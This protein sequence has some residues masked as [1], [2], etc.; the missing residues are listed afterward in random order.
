MSS[1]QG[2]LDYLGPCCGYSRLSVDRLGNKI[3]YEVQQ[4]PS[5]SWAERA[6]T[7]IGHWYKD[8]NESA[9]DKDVFRKDFEEMLAD[10]RAGLWK[11]IIVWRIDRLT[12]RSGQFEDI[13]EMLE[14]V[15]GF[16]YSV[17][18]GLD[19]RNED[20]LMMMKIKVVLGDNEV[21]GTKRRLR[22]NKGAKT[23]A[24]MYTGG[25]RR[26]YGFEGPRHDEHG[27]V[28]NTGRVG[29]AHV[30]AEVAILRDAARRIA[31]EGESY[32][33]VITDWH[34]R[35]EPIYGATGAPWNTKT[36]QHILTAPRI[37][38]MQEYR[39]PETGEKVLVK[40][41]WE[42]V[43]DDRTWRRLVAMRNPAGKNYN[44]TERYLLTN[45]ALCGHCQR[46]L[47]GSQRTYKKGGEAV[48]TRCYR[49]PSHT[50]YKARGHCGKLNVIADPV[51][52]IVV[53]HMLVRVRRTQ[54]V[55]AA[56]GA[57]HDAI[58]ES[59]GELEAKRTECQAQ[60][61]EVKAAYTARRI[62]MAEWLEVRDPVQA[63]M[64]SLETQMKAL[65]GR[66]DVPVPVG[67]ELDDLPAWFERLSFRQ[68]KAL[69]DA[70]VEQ[71]VV[72]PPGRSG[73]YFKPE[74]VVVTLTDLE[75][76]DGEGE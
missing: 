2:L 24:G 23:K 55:V 16:I 45:K 46:G 60:L 31:W 53:A 69:V 36:L 11:G 70:H 9:A 67:S 54:G 39:D 74:R 13:V 22:A 73:R 48:P 8:K 3:G 42:P 28:T 49:C 61:D 34:G 21:K 66:L 56:F 27:R 15:G 35:A 25:G 20:D 63:E 18:E 1:S 57:S 38:G 6:G 14:A 41:Q 7:A 68:Q 51:E 33:D 26:P 4:T 12:R 43:L 40:A 72:L 59:L 71:V 50:Q 32:V 65:T 58:F 29:V 37:V 52:K 5:D 62:S 47:S 17:D 30:E 10:V 64:E 75:V 44:A 76:A 19:S